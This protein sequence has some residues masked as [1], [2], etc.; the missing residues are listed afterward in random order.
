M[1]ST[2]RMSAMTGICLRGSR[3][4]A[5]RSERFQSKRPSLCRDRMVRRS[6][7]MKACSWTRGRTSPGRLRNCTDICEEPVR[8]L[9]DE[10]SSA[11]GRRHV[12]PCR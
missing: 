12:A 2:K 7:R 3:L 8:G 9:S 11:V 5:A 1:A 4:L 6:V 10:A